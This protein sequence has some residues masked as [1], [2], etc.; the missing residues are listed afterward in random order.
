MDSISLNGKYII[1][2]TIKLLTGARIGGTES[3]FAIGGV[4]NPIIRNPINGQPYIPGS[5]LKGKMRAL[6]E[7]VHQMP[8]NREHKSGGK[9]VR[10]HE[11]ANHK[12]I[13]C[14]VYGSSEDPK[15]SGNSSESK[16]I[17][18]RIIVRDAHLTQESIRL[19][20]MMDTDTP[21]AEI[22]SENALDRITS[23]SSP[24]QAERVPAGVEFEFEI[25]YTDI[26]YT[27]KELGQIKINPKEDILNILKTLELIEQDYIGGYGS[28]GYGKV[29]FS[30][31]EFTYKP[32]EYYVQHKEESVK[33]FITQ[34]TTLSEAI[35]K[36]K[37]ENI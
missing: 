8:L 21:Y 30:I 14:R 13:V 1:R 4:D 12:C 28:R 7:K 37:S 5:S 26:E 9:K 20:E 25:I 19:L 24:R 6:M 27:T 11:C 15:E 2:G 35:D 17:P 18:S 23:F 10:R 33:H 29:E 22:K 31:S 3:G 36:I 32:R 16:N 34:K